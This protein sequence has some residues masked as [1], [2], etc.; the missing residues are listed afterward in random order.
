MFYVLDSF[1]NFPYLSSFFLVVLPTNK[2][3]RVAYDLH[4]FFLIQRVPISPTALFTDVI[5]ELMV[6]MLN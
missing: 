4:I 1:V 6:E 2:P 5:H 3:N